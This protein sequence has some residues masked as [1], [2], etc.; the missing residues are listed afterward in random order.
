LNEIFK[1]LIFN[2]CGKKRT[3]IPPG[4]RESE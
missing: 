1:N 3:R 4:Y 2:L